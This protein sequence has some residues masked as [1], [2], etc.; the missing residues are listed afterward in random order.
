MRYMRVP[1][2]PNGQAMNRDA[3]SPGRRQYP[4]PTP[5][6]ARYSSPTTPGGTGR[7]HSSSTKNAA[8]VTGDPIGG[9]PVPACSGVL[10]Q[11][12]IVVS[13]GP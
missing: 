11:A 3:V 8:R 2:S 6:P 7:S 4:A 9:N 10:L 1:G 5:W 13:V 12:H